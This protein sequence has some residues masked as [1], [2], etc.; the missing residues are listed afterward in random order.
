MFQYTFKIIK[1]IAYTIR[2]AAT[3]G[4]CLLVLA[5]FNPERAEWKQALVLLLATFLGSAYCFLLNDIFDRKKDLLNDKKRPLV[6]GELPVKLAFLVTVLLAVG[7]VASSWFLG[8]IPFILAFVFLIIASFYSLINVKT[9]ILAN[10]IVAFVVS[11]TQWGVAIIKPDP[12][13]W[14]SSSFLFFYTIPREILLD[15]LD[16]SGDKKFGKQS[17]PL[18]FSLRKLKWTLITTLALA[19]VSFV[20]AIQ[21]YLSNTLSVALG[22]FVLLFTWLSFLPFFKT[23]DHAQALSSVRWSHVTFVF[24]IFTLLSR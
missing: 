2:P 23:S 15:W 22:C 19:S 11:G 12:I 4:A 20:I 3:F 24:L 8:M 18:N 13:L 10:I 5:G 16:M 21:L 14:I 7:F 17:A 6:T 9:G 1:A